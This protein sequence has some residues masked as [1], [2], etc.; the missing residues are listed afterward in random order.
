MAKVLKKAK[1]NQINRLRVNSASTGMLNSS[2][3]YTWEIKVGSGS[4]S[5]PIWND[6][7]ISYETDERT[8]PISKPSSHVYVFGASSNYIGEVYTTD[9]EFLFVTPG[10]YLI[11]C[12]INTGDPD[13]VYPDD[14]LSYEYTVGNVEIVVPNPPTL[15]ITNK[16]TTICAGNLTD[17]F[18]CDYGFGEYGDTYTITANYGTPSTVNLYTQLDLTESIN[19]Y[20]LGEIVETDVVNPLNDGSIIFKN[21]IKI[22]FNAKQ[23]LGNKPKFKYKTVQISGGIKQVESTLSTFE[24]YALYQRPSAITNAYLAKIENDNTFTQIGYLPV[25]SGT[26]TAIIKFDKSNILQYYPDDYYV[27]FWVRLVYGTTSST[28]LKITKFSNTNIWKYSNGTH[29]SIG[30][31]PIKANDVHKSEWYSKIPMSSIFDI[32]QFDGANGT[33]LTF[34]VEIFTEV[35]KSGYNSKPAFTDESL[36]SWMTNKIITATDLSYSPRGLGVVGNSQYMYGYN[37]VWNIFCTQANGPKLIPCDISNSSTFYE[38]ITNQQKYIT[39]ENLT[40]DL[41]NNICSYGYRYDL[42]YTTINVKLTTLS[43]C[44]TG[45]FPTPGGTYFVNNATVYTDDIAEPSLCLPCNI[46]TLYATEIDII[47]NTIYD[48]T[49]KIKRIY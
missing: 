3:R 8:I 18:K 19:Q 30:T 29:T 17:I 7:I 16:T 34:N 1:I 35:Y 33:N 9:I 48:I 37:Y 24:V 31:T 47:D 44:P 32:I 12:L 38:R 15:S 43:N 45:P 40:T 46:N 14:T 22:K 23:Y 10:K 20:E 25:I 21:W 6:A 41:A 42:L 4:S 27:N 13:C 26:E 39:S 36:G 5:N 11:Q 28:S 49:G 2:W